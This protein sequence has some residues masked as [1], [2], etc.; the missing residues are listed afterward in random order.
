MTRFGPGWP[1]DGEPWDALA[2]DF[3]PG[4]TPGLGIETV[5]LALQPAFGGRRVDLVTRRGLAPRLRAQI[6]ATEVPLY[7]A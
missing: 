1:A 3:E 2:E 5:A 7:G 4:M 6:V